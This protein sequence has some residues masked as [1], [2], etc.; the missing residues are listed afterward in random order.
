MDN[1]HSL[2]VTKQWDIKG[3]WYVTQIAQYGIVYFSKWALGEQKSSPSIVKELV[4][5]K[6][7]EGVIAEINNEMNLESGTILLTLSAK[8][9]AT[10]SEKYSKL[11]YF[12]IL[13]T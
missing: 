4:G 9:P 11:L 1:M 2:S 5:S 10:C 3:Y 12:K 13:W 6:P 7:S 8:Q